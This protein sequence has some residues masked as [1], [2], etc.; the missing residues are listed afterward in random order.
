MKRLA[1]ICI[2]GLCLS[3]VV[4]QAAKKKDKP[5]VC[6]HAYMPTETNWKLGVLLGYSNSTGNTVN[7]A[8]NSAIHVEYSPKLWQ[9][10]LDLTAQTKSANHVRTGEKYTESFQ[11]RYHFKPRENY[12]YGLAQAIQDPFATYTQTALA[13]TGYGW[14]LI[15][16]CRFYLLWQLGPGMRYQKLSGSGQQ[17]TRFVGFTQASFTWYITKTTSLN[18]SF[19]VETN[20][21]NTYW[22][23]KTSIETKLIK[24]FGLNISYQ[25]DYNTN[26]PLESANKYKLDTST[27]VAIIYNFED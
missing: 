13:S 15:D 10:L 16:N 25:M 14:T 22:Q 4:A 17:T 7:S 9:Y 24:N 27:V 21:Q 12:L 5:K 6:Q 23:S 20:K 1:A 11:A 2:T 8:L 26:I 18:Q 3:T 19:D